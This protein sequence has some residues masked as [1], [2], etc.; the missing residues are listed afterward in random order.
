MQISYLE[1][2]KE[3]P[4]GNLFDSY[5]VS[6][7]I[8]SF[9]LYPTYYKKIEFLRLYILKIHVPHKLMSFLIAIINNMLM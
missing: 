3:R 2:R 1:I 8:L 6:L 9:I 4:K 5:H 7:E